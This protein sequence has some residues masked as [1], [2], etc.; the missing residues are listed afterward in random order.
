MAKKILLC[1]WLFF[2][3]LGPVVSLYAQTSPN[4]SNINTKAYQ[5]DFNLNVPIGNVSKFTISNTSNNI[6]GKYIQAWYG[7][8]IGTVG[9]I[10]TV[11]IMWGGLKFLASRGDRTMVGNAQSI[12]ISALTGLVLAFGS[13]TILYL[14]NPNLLTIRVPALQRIVDNSGINLSEQQLADI[15]SGE[16]TASAN[17]TAAGGSGSVSAAGLQPQTLGLEADLKTLCPDARL[18]SGYRSGE[19]SNHGKGTAMDFG[20]GSCDSTFT[21]LIDQYKLGNPTWGYNSRDGKNNGYDLNNVTINGH[22]Y[23]ILRIIDERTCWHVDFD[24]ST[25][26]NFGLK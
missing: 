15:G 5:Q 2:L 13:Y 8:L 17:A 26:A 7:F 12:I 6:L 21:N 1:L 14:I 9:I 11:M 16:T 3:L 24:P 22:T 20:R 19:G 23:P 18:T 10:A 4:D 25:R